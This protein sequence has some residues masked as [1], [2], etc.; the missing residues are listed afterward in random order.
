[1]G[2]GWE[3]AWEKVEEGKKGDW[4]R[5]KGARTGGETHLHFL[6]LAF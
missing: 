5:E 2:E 1:M 6:A 3:R 4:G